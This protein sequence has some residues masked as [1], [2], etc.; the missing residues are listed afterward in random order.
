MLE[1]MTK[2]DAMAKKV[3]AQMV[4]NPDAAL[5][6]LIQ[7]SIANGGLINTEVVMQYLKAAQTLR[8]SDT[9]ENFLT[10]VRPMIEALVSAF[11]E[12]EKLE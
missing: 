7:L 6:Q 12:M 3:M 4:L 5:E 1:Q 8:A 11:A 9:L 2:G 10:K